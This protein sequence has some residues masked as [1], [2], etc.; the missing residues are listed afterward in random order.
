MK[1]DESVGFVFIQGA[2]LDRSIWQPVTEG[3]DIPYLLV[4]S[5]ARQ[6]SGKERNS[7]SLKDYA[8]CISEQIAKWKVK[9]FVLV[10]HSLGGVLAM[11]LAEKLGDRIVG[12]VAIGAAIPQPGSSFLSVLPAAKRLA[13]RVLL[14]AFGTKPPERAIRKGLCK[15]LPS[16][17][18]SEI[19]QRFCPESIRLYTDRVENTLPEVPKLYIKLAKDEE[20]SLSQQERMIE[21]FQPDLV[22]TFQTGHLPMLSRPQELRNVLRAF[23]LQFVVH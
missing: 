11:E 16:D 10:A 7:L 5:P 22:E 21:N 23:L 9:K 14:G 6:Q 4:D 20:L 15:E 1:P 13:L 12:A 2:G 8:A 19:V 18:A 3:L 17:Q